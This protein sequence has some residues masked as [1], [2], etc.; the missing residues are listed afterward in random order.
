MS[1]LKAFIANM[2]KSNLFQSSWNY[3]DNMSVRVHKK[4]GKVEYDH[5]DDWGH[6]WEDEPM[7]DDMPMWS[8]QECRL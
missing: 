4:T 6:W 8:A 3:Y 5:A 7:F 2:F 1:K